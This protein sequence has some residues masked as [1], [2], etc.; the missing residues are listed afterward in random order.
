MAFMT[1]S[2]L[3][4][5]SDI[6]VVAAGSLKD[7]F[8]AI[9]A[10]YT[11]AYGVTFSPMW[12]PSGILRQRLQDGEEFDVFASAALPHAQALTDC[13]VS[14]PAVLFARNALC[15]V[16]NTDADVNQ[17]NLTA[18][19]LRPDVRIGTSTPT[20]DP[21]GDYTW[22]LFRKI[23]ARQPGAFDLLSGKALQ[24]FGGATTTSLVNGR[25]R[26]VAALDADEIDLFVYYRSSAQQIVSSSPQYR[27]VE[28]PA[29]LSVGAEYGLTVSRTAAPG[30]ADFAAHLLSDQGQRLLTSFG[31]IPV[32]R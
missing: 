7:A 12:G 32:T 21:G 26:L 27:L 19:L 10:D 22:E 20:A 9:F 31:F 16:T 3:S 6:R 25:H 11:K 28:L 2:P 24:L 4:S 1:A 18:T 15:I 14:G 30:A 17:N 8:T 29:E 5:T 13:G 23:D